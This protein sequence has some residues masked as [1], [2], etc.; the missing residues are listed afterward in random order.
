MDPHTLITIARIAFVILAS[1]IITVHHIVHD[2][3][4]RNT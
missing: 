1:T 3:K 4:K 2:R